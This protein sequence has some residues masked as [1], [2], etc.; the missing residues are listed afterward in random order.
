MTDALLHTQ[1]IAFIVTNVS[2]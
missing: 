2:M 1:Q